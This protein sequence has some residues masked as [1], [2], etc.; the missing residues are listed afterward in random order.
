MARCATAA[1]VNPARGRRHGL[2]EILLALTVVGF[3][4][5]CLAATAAAAPL[6]ELS[7]DR[8]KLLR[9][10]ER[11]Q[12]QIAEKYYREKNWKVALAE[13]EKFLTL[14]ERSEG[15]PYAQLKWSLCQVQLRKLNT[16]I[17]EGFQSVIDYWPESEDAVTSAY[18][19][20]K[21][22]KDMGETKKAKQAYADLLKKHD[23]HLVA[24]MARVDLLDIARL[25]N[26]NSRRVQL[27]R[28]L[29]FNTE[30]T[31]DS[32]SACVEASRQLAVYY[33]YSGA[34]AEAQKALATTYT[35]EQLP[36]QIV[37]YARGPI[38]ELTAK[39]ET[40]GQGEKVAEAAV[41]YIRSILPADL[42]AAE[43]KALARNYWFQIADLYAAARRAD[44]VPET[45]ELMTKQFGAD[46]E[47]L[48]RLAG[49]YKSQNQR[50]EARKV[51]GRFENKFEGQ[52]QVAYSYREE[53]KHDQAIAIYRVIALQDAENAPRWK[54]ELA[55]TYRSAGKCDEA[56][57]VYRELLVED[58]GRAGQW[59]WAI[60]HTY[61]DF[62]RYKDAIAA[63]RQSDNFPEAYK[64]MAWC[65]RQLKEW[66]EALAL[67][68]QVM[69]SD[70]P[71]AP[72]ALLQ[73]GYT[74]EQAGDKEKA[75][76]AL[77][78]VCKK[79]PKTGQASEA[80][81]YLQDKFNIQVTLGGE[82]EE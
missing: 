50:D 40:K 48:G 80:H 20:A 26:D 39:P 35:E 65:H 52:H 10:A 66:K 16:A 15:A 55:S 37:I 64:Q 47:L 74:Q 32:N 21:T 1:K 78:Q 45:Y 9:E 28:E 63:F 22:Y 13:Y 11:Y 34:F 4:A 69:G 38:G 41:A 18:L 5:S 24:V 3:F 6:D 82:T 29:T 46:D 25:E 51:Y 23:K 72:W 53:Q 44:K 8:W 17:K 56:V 70:E 62:G 58:A 73:I 27:W 33:F 31:R 7:L 79:Y 49:W 12:L 30:R 71:S 61:R 68:A 59:Q 81:A 57:A 42:T 2:R 76:K 19:I 60:A 67:Y 43:S 77:Q 75:I 54:S 14:Y 36:A